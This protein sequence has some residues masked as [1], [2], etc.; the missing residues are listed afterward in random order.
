M[1]ILWILIACAAGGWYWL[2]GSRQISESDV[3]SYY[4]Q[5]LQW[6]DEGKS[7]E[8]CDSLD[9]KYSA[10]MVQV[11]ASGR[12]VEQFDKA[13]NC[14]ATEVL[15][16]SVKKLNDTMGGGVVFNAQN[17]LNKIELS[18]D[19]KT[20]TVSVQSILKMGTEKVL[21]MKMTSESTETFIKRNGKLLRL[22]AEGEVL[23]E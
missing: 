1:K 11:S 16:E 18:S 7:K 20:A 5:E 8:M 23:V 10:R 4:T 19:K 3:Q 12:V 21:M 14:H 6:L 17:N 9:E 2:V 22:S 13:K 15:F